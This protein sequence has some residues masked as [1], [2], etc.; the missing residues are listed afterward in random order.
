[1]EQL[2]I[3]TQGAVRQSW[4]HDD[5]LRQ[6][7]RGLMEA[8]PAAST[9]EIRRQHWQWVEE[10]PGLLVLLHQYWFDNH[11]AYLRAKRDYKAEEERRAER[12]V[13]R[14]KLTDQITEEIKKKIVVAAPKIALLTMQ[15]PIGKPIKDC[16][17]PE[18]EKLA[19]IIGGWLMRVAHKVGPRKV[20]AVLNEKQ[21]RELY[22]Q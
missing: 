17:G 19:P 20:G 10:N 22:Q 12:A 9:E 8:S 15:M 6:K 3:G 21:L 1:M 14:S 7:L 11:V 4:T 16:T 18:C 13:E 5:T 2:S